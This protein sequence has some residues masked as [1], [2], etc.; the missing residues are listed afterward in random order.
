MRGGGGDS[1][2][3]TCDSMDEAVLLKAMHIVIFVI[4]EKE[5]HEASITASLP[6]CNNNSD[7]M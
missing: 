3:R 2:D 6:T 1:I 5:P 7:V 4:E